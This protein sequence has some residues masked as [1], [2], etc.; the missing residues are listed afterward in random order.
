MAFAMSFSL[1][2]NVHPAEA[3]TV[4]SH[5]KI[6]VSDADID[7]MLSKGGYV[8]GEAVAV[9]TGEWDSGSYK[10][11][12]ISK[13]ETGIIK[14]I[15]DKDRTTGQILKSLYQ[16]PEVIF[17]EP[18]YI[19]EAPEEV[20]NK[21]NRKSITKT[22]KAADISTMPGNTG[23]MT[24][25][26]WFV[27][28]KTASE[29]LTP[30]ANK[31]LGLHMGIP[32]WNG[33]ADNA[34]GTVAIIDTGL[35][36][37]HPDLKDS[38]YTF[39]SEQQQK[40]GCGP[41]GISF[42]DDDPTD[43]TDYGGHGTHVAGIIAGTWN[44]FGISGIAKGI[45]V[46][47]VRVFDKSGSGQ[48]E[49]SILKALEWL[50]KVAKDVNLKSINMSLGTMRSQLVYTL[51]F[52]KLG[53]LGVNTV[54]ASGN[55]KNDLDETV[56]ISGQSNSPYVIVVN[57]NDQDGAP[58]S[59]SCWGQKS[60]DVYSSGAQ[61]LSTVPTGITTY[62][63]DGELINSYRNI[64]FFPHKT[65]ASHL[66]NGKIQSFADAD[67][68]V[69]FFDQCPVNADGKDNTK[70]KQVGSLV[71]G[72]GLGIHDDVSW[73]AKPKT[74]PMGEGQYMVDSYPVGRN[75]W[76][77]IPLDE[78][79]PEWLTFFAAVNDE[80]HVY[81]GISG[82]VCAKTGK[83]GQTLPA[84]LDMTYD[85]DL[86]NRKL[87][88]NT[89]LGIPASCST[90]NL[91]WSQFNIN[92][93]DY[94][95]ELQYF[96][97]K[98]PA[99]EKKNMEDPGEITGIY[100]WNKDGKSYL[101]TQFAQTIGD[102]GEMITDDTVLYID[103]IALGDS[104]AAT[105]A[106]QIMSGTSMAAPTVAAALTVIAKDEPANSS[107]TD[108]QLG[109]T[110]L[111]RAAKLLASVDYDDNLKDKCSTGGRVNLH[112]KTTFTEKAPIIS[113]AE[114]KDETLTV[115]GYFFGASGK[116]YIDGTETAPL[117]WSETT[118][119]VDL[120]TVT[121]GSH[122][123]MIVNPD[124]K[125]AQSVFAMSGGVL[126]ENTYKVPFDDPAFLSDGTM[127]F[128]G[129]M[130]TDGRYIFVMSSDS[131]QRSYALWRFDTKDKTWFRCADLPKKVYNLTAENNGT[132][133]KGGKLYMY[134]YR[135]GLDSGKGRIWT[136]D[137]A[138]NKWKQAF[139]KKL[140]GSGQIFNIGKQAFIT[141]DW[142]F[143][144]LN[145]KNG[146]LKKVKGTTSPIDD[147]TESRIA[148]SGKK[149][150]IYGYSYDEKYNREY[151][152]YRYTYNKKK[153]KFI[154]QDLKKA[155]DK[156]FG[157][158]LECRDAA[159]AAVPKGVMIIGPAA[160]GTLYRQD[161]HFI[162][163]SSKKS[164]LYDKTACFHHIYSRKAVYCGGQLYVLGINDTEPDVLFL[165][166]T[167]VK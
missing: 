82:F 60:T 63:S 84:I 15:V 44:N 127:D 138:G 77:A 52:N 125:R 19:C 62:N 157:S 109:V 50:T 24:G 116:V 135:S 150:Y 30:V 56:D 70:A 79:D 73:S 88:I 45:K 7:S 122:T 43:V 129:Q 137:I 61:I 31:G 8:E 6:S 94:I 48:E 110:A 76:M 9:V 98:I 49:T 159:M 100:K 22:D 155:I 107:L 39:T 95:T 146:K 139:K 152:L 115:S 124:Q 128:S 4:V 55:D 5:Q 23:D 72:A 40:Y 158:E 160:D 20:G 166:S 28:D 75:V 105:G 53:E 108:E 154:R 102:D 34:S 147:I 42:E 65:D 130:S 162:G 142:K 11:E 90:S 80:T 35:D 97:D 13:V 83:N 41:H 18:N 47:S 112:G 16:D 140:P 148:V 86:S 149:L 101:L 14:R 57:A 37:D 120:S 156:T 67:Q 136:Y 85:N 114:E 132:I 26:Q 165:R 54:I 92:I 32:G 167:T 46:F 151:H 161:T 153:N 71:H 69:L 111:E 96:H 33:T 78:K 81:S 141:H 163:N 117:S 106:Y 68:G 64:R 93:K 145:L 66:I 103:S 91:S 164:T 12:T 143:K 36:C 126:Y 134:F 10:T 1:V 58:A 74:L 89:S 99:K 25:S 27:N 21:A 144:K 59:F 104:E 17:A 121:A 113:R 29:I 87:D 133:V 38:L 119:T 3:K 131:V 51:L 123:V 2:G 118:V